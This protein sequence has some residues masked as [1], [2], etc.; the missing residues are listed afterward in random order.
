MADLRPASRTSQIFRPR[1]NG[2]DAVI[3]TSD[4]GFYDY[5]ELSACRAGRGAGTMAQRD[6]A[7]HLRRGAR[8]QRRPELGP[9]GAAA[10]SRGRR[11]P[12]PLGPAPGRDFRPF[13]RPGRL[14]D[15]RSHDAGLRPGDGRDHGDQPARRRRGRGAMS[16]RGRPAGPPARPSAPSRRE[17]T[18]APSRRWRPRR[19]AT[20]RPSSS[21]SRATPASHTSGTS[22]RGAA[23]LDLRSQLPDRADPRPRQRVRSPPTA[24]PAPPRSPCPPA[25]GTGVVELELSAPEPPTR[26]SVYFRRLNRHRKSDR[27]LPLRD[28]NREVHDERTW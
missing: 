9:V 4:E 27:G 13:R 1:L 26:S 19:W 24:R 3:V 21:T 11:L 28:R 15:H 23:T 8:R 16:D 7:R 25:T 6:P 17:P 20:T 2:Q 22:S 5:A 10:H 12:E 14:V 18:C